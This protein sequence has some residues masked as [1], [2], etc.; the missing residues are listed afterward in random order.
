MRLINTATGELRDFF[1]T[2]KPKYSILS[3]TWG[4]D[5]ISYL[6]FLLLTSNASSTSAGL[7]QMLL[8]SPRKDSQGFRKV[9]AACK[10]A[11]SR[12]FEWI[13]IDSVCI[14]KSSS[15]ELS[16]AI[17]S[18]WRWYSDATECFVYLF[19]VSP[20]QE[21]SSARW[22]TRGWTLQELLAPKTVIF[23]DSNW[24]VIATKASMA[25]QISEITR[26]PLIFLDGSYSPTDPK[27]TSVAMK[28]SWVSRR[29]TT[30]TE[31]MAYCMFGLFDG[32]R[33]KFVNL[34]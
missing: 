3:H 12:G 28:M 1:D 26:I 11:Q 14:D 17:N 19:D 20:I 27:V 5:E 16:E 7:V 29:E 10:F 6:D 4:S 33:W 31:D 18:M 30:R 23:C 34:G 9:E 2:Q 21:F 13:W 15:A 8:R 22:F 25:K 32:E 24:D